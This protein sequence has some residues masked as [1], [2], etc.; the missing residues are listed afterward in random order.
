MHVIDDCN[1]MPA[2]YMLTDL[3]I[4]AS[5]D[6]EAFGR[7][8]V[9]AQALGRPVVATDHGG[10]RETVIE[11]VTGWLTPPGDSTAL[12]AAIGHAL[13]LTEEQR[14]RLNDRAI[15]HVRANYTKELMSRRTLDVYNELLRE[16]AVDG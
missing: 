5:T 7:V 13:S 1:D 15:E 6:P 2:A 12:A 11:G 4:S 14:L 8:I 3:V 10:A 9:E 16:H